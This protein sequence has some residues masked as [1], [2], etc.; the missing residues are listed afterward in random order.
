M[1]WVLAGAA[2]SLGAELS[3]ELTLAGVLARQASAPADEAYGRLRAS[4][5]HGWHDGA[6]RLEAD[7][8]ALGGSAARLPL[9]RR[10]WQEPPSF[11]DATRTWMHRRWL[12][13]ATVHRAEISQWLGPARVRVGRT[14]LVW[15]QGKLWPILDRLVPVPPTALEPEQ[16]PGMD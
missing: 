15:G 13:R 12:A 8:E 16:R 6:L 10:A 4:W 5:A 7:L 11:A 3:W 1:L 9:V 14:A 2:P